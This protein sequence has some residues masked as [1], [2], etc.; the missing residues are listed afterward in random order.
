MSISSAIQTIVDE[1]PQGSIFDSH[2]VIKELIKRFSD[3]YLAFVSDF[4][5]NGN[6]KLTLTAHGQIGKEIKKLKNVRMLG[7]AWSE[8][9]HQTPSKCTCWKKK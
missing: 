9:I 5:V 2:F 8:N 7:D 3:D 1:V 6:N 4:A